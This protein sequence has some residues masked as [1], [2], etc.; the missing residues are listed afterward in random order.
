M[1]EDQKLLKVYK[2]IFE[3]WRS[4]VNSYWQR[5]NYF[6]AFE[7]AAIAGCWHIL[8]TPKKEIWAGF[9]MACLGIALT[10]V[11]LYNNYKTHKY[12]VYWW[13]ALGKLEK[14]IRLVEY[15]ADFVTRQIGGG[16]CMPYHCLVQVVPAI[17][18]IAW[19]FLFVWSLW[20]SCAC[21]G[22]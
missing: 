18:L 6:A 11:W 14:K 9:I 20:L 1:D 2:Q 22:H 16:G 15:E 4:Q 17:F 8:T 12:V 10:I 3:T 21:S 13:D 5:S 7:T 19:L